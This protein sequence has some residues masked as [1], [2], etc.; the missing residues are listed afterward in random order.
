M[1]D[2]NETT[3]T[4]GVQKTEHLKLTYTMV[5]ELGA[6]ERHFNQMQS[7]YRSFASAWLLAAFGAM[8]YV[9]AK[10][11]SDF[12]IPPELLVGCIAIAAAVG[13][14]L[15]WHMDARIYHRLLQACFD[16][17]EQLEQDE[18]ELPK[19][20]KRMQAA[21]GEENVANSIGLYYLVP[22]AAMALIAMVAFA[23]YAWRAYCAA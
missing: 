14:W 17:A 12:L 8:G 22:G 20:R 15:L 11:R 4:A 1:A 2:S 7:T 3:P 5:Q 16:T 9:L 18:P 23:L 19:F 21:L 10:P 13:I 6:Y